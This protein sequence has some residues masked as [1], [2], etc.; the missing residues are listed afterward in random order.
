[1]ALG[2]RHGP[3]RT[4]A[5]LLPGEMDGAFRR[6]PIV[7][8]LAAALVVVGVFQ[9]T[10]L[11]CFMADP[12]LRWA[13]AFP[14]NE[15]GVRHM[16]LSAYVYAAELARRGD[17][18]VYLEE[19]YPAFD[20]RSGRERPPRSSA[21]ANLIPHLRDAFEYPPPFLL[22]PGAALV[23]SNDFLVIRTGWFMIQAPLF[24]LLVLGLAR[25]IDG[26]RGTIATVLL[27]GLLSSF[28][29]LF[30][31]QFGQFQLAAVML[32]TGGMLAFAKKREFLGG[33]LL[34]G[35]IVTKVFP[36]FLVVY[37]IVRKRGRAVLYTVALSA[38]Y[39][40][41]ALLVYGMA[42]Y[43]AFVGYQLPRILSGE[44]FSFFKN[45][46]LTLAANSSVYSIPFKLERLG[47]PGMNEGLASTLVWI[48]T[49]LLIAATVIAARRH[50]DP[51][52]EPAV[53]LAVLALSGLRSPDAPNVYIGATALWALSLVV[54]ETRGR[55]VPILLAAL[56][57][58]CMAVQPPLPDPKAT[59]VLWLS[60]P[61]AILSFGFWEMV[62]RRT[63][64]G[65]GNR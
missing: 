57:W 41:A 55:P 56:A 9:T 62:R 21:V 35:A 18:N 20:F 53:W 19:H 49:A 48:F 1:V 14:P 46:D 28:S 13:S 8:C 15:F 10:R 17:P 64:S 45:A 23:L 61:A 47:V 5:R 39:V 16:C 54:S 22:L 3:L 42:P 27:F 26:R 31:F 36:G 6:R 63:A 25:H 37:L 34:A 40:L 65:E 33:A 24:I 32:A 44:A 11:S 38:V 2:R 50:R 58:I 51:S 43:R 52:L 4:I 30:N 60:G 29:V 12:S 59:I 7:A